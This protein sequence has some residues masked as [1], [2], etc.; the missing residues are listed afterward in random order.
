RTHRGDRWYVQGNG[1]TLPRLMRRTLGGEVEAV[2]NVESGTRLA[3]LSDGDLLLSKPEICNN[4]NTYYDL[5]R[6]GPGGRLRRL[7]E[8]GRFRFAAPLE[9]GR[10]AAIRV[11]SGEA[12][13]VLLNSRGEL[14]RSLDRA[15]TGAA[16]AASRAG[17]KRGTASRKSA[18]H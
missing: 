8:C 5:Y 13:V 2:R 6:L 1:Y 18:R 9:D 15:A 16:T 17:P 4:Y 3:A 14:E 10:I 12:E 7:T 11:V